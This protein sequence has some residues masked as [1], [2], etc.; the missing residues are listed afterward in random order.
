MSQKQGA[1][2]TGEFVVDVA[3]KIIDGFFVIFFSVVFLFCCYAIYDAMSIY[4]SADYRKLAKEYT[5][6]DEQGNISEV[7]LEGLRK[8]NS[9]I[10]GWIKLDDMEV[11]F[12]V[13]HTDSNRFYLTHDYLKDYSVS[14][15]IFLDMDN[16]ADF[17]DDFN[18]IY[19]HNMN[20]EKM[21]GALGDYA[22]EDFFN[23]HTHGTLFLLDKKYDLDLI[24]FLTTTK[25]DKLIYDVILSNNGKN[26]E[27]YAH[28]D[29]DAAYRRDYHRSRSILALST[30]FSQSGSRGIVF[31]NLL[32]SD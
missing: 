9:D 23:S 8:Q 17:T 6:E 13:V 12:P 22:R 25:D 10:I 15:S 3:E 4:D 19:G 20:G 21:F 5:N 28:L 11:S 31:F 32:P 1:K 7:D 29:K 14:G 30:C 16:K 27:I 18:L 2:S 26:D 24:A